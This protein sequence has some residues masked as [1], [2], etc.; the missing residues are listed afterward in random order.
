MKYY[1]YRRIPDNIESEEEKV[2]LINYAKSSNTELLKD[3]ITLCPISYS[4]F[5]QNTLLNNTIDK[6]SPG[7]I[8]IIDSLESLGNSSSAILQRLHE[9]KKR[10]VELHLDKQIFI[11]KPADDVYKIL[12]SLFKIDHQHKLSKE[13]KVIATLEKSKKLR[14]RKKAKRIKSIFDKH[15]N[16]IMR[17][18]ALGVTKKGIIK[19]IEVG[20]AQALS[21]Y[22]KRIKAENIEKEKL[23]KIEK[24]Q[25]EAYFSQGMNFMKTIGSTPNKNK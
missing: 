5:K 17:Q 12:D 21:K 1:A 20:D 23:A 2:R 15:K 25:D 4:L 22:I 14:G 11:L 16:I 24:E 18:D 9:I 6:L 13:K 7:D 10:R 19:N 3:D 8:L